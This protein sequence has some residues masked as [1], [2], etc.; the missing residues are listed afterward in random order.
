MPARS[1]SATEDFSDDWT[2]GVDASP[3][4]E[5]P[6]APPQG[7][8]SLCLACGAEPLRGECPH[9]EVVT[10]TAP[11]AAVLSAARQLVRLTQERRSAERALRRQVELALL[12][13][14]GPV[15][16]SRRA[17]APVAPAVTATSRPRRRRGAPEGQGAFAFAGVDPA[18]DENPTR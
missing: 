12:R 2:D 8:V 7:P 16:I 17:P 4:A 11:G 9:D 14:D 1:P 5:G 3:G 18:G 10:L 6:S 13:G 15:E